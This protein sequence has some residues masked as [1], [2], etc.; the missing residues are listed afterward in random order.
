MQDHKLAIVALRGAADDGDIRKHTRVR[1]EVPHHDAICTVEHDV[2]RLAQ[3]IRIGGRKRRLYGIDVCVGVQQ[4]HGLRHR[5]CLVHPNTR[6]RMQDLARKITAF[7]TV[8]VHY[9][10]VT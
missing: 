5:S 1:H 7:D 6:I 4:R 3:L 8:I 9:G 2:V 10:N